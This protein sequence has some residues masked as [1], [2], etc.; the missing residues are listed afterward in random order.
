[1]LKKIIN[2]WANIWEMECK[3]EKDKRLNNHEI[4]PT[5]VGEA[6]NPW[7]CMAFHC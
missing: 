5:F 3:T 2:E 6:E 4:M 7:M 1:M